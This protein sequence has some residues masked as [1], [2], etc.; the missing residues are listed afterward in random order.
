MEDP[1]ITPYDFIGLVGVCFTLFNYAYLQW[2]RDYAKDLRY[3]AGNLLGS[4]LLGFSLYNQW[5]LSSF[6]ITS[7]TG[8]ISIYGVYRCMKYRIRAQQID[9]RLKSRL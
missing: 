6:V 8:L 5:N 3:S 9:L 4:V 2:R 1:M 7:I